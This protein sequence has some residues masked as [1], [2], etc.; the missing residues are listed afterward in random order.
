MK[1]YPQLMKIRQSI[2]RCDGYIINFNMYSDLAMSLS[3]EIEERHITELHN[4]LQKITTISDLDSTGLSHES[5][6]EWMILM[7][8]SFAKGTGNMKHEKPMVDG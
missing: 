2:L 6:K 7:N 5:N 1:E 3:I 8:I 4:S